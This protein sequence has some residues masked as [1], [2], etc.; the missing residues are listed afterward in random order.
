MSY[1]V[2]TI[3]ATMSRISSAFYLACPGNGG[4]GT[5][6]FAANRLYPMPIFVGAGGTATKVGIEV[7]TN[8][9]GN[10]RLGI[11][12]NDPA[13]NLPGTLLVDAGVVATGTTGTK[14][15]TI[16][17][18][19]QSNTW[20][21]TAV[22][23]DATATVRAVANTGALFAG[24]LNPASPSSSIY[25]YRAFTYAALPANE[26]AATYTFEATTMPPWVWIRG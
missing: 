24:F 4:T 1:I 12:N 2:G 15:I 21:W 22:V 26:S 14:E 7:T 6:Q 19:L 9:S 8:V 5:L 20:Y 23:S 3:P 25:L 13:R 10:A 16:S 11:Y 17:Q 18:V